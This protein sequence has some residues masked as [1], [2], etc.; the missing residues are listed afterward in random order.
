MPETKNETSI[1][2][3]NCS[4]ITK[5]IPTLAVF[6]VAPVKHKDD[7][8]P[9]GHFQVIQYSMLLVCYSE[10]KTQYSSI[11]EK[12]R[13]HILCVVHKSSLEKYC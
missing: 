4:Q 5:R 8:F 7:A 6:L 1:I 13:L 11:L 3:E 2:R 9:S 12:P 10:D